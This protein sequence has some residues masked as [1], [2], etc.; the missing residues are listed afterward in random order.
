MQIQKAIEQLGFSSKEAKVY[1]AALHLGE[2]HISDIAAMVKMPRSSVQIII[3]K[4][5]NEGLIN[6]YVMR[7][8]KYWVAEN[9]ERLL[10][11]LENR[12][13]IIREVMPSLVAIKKTNWGKRLKTIDPDNNRGIFRLLADSC[14]Q[15][16]LIVNDHVTIEYINTAWE[17]QFGYTLQE[18]CG[19]NPRIFQSGKTLQEIYTQLWSSLRA[20]KMFQSDKIIDKKKDGTCFNI[21]TTIF[22]L[23]H[24]GRLFYIQILEDITDTIRQTFTRSISD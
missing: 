20:E 4:L 18:V 7:R 13:K 2:S 12:E 1:L 5:H 9:P 23:R 17:K 8:S 24:N 14:C 15:P 10:Q 11:N 21:L 6:F 19:E 3:D 22:P 16:V